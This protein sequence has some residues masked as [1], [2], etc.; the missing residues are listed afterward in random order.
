MTK[1]ILNVLPNPGSNAI[2]STAVSK[3]PGQDDHGF[4]DQLTKAR[5]DA[6][7]STDTTPSRQKQSAVRSTASVKKPQTGQNASDVTAETSEATDAEAAATAQE[8][9]PQPPIDEPVKPQAPQQSGKVK[10]AAAAEDSQQE[11]AAA[12]DPEQSK[13]NGQLP[14][15][16]QQI[17]AATAQPSESGKPTPSPQRQSQAHDDDAAASSD[18]SLA[19]ASAA[20]TA[21]VATLPKPSPSQP[22]SATPQAQNA[23]G[24]QTDDRANVSP[25]RGEDD[26]AKDA[27]AKTSQSGQTQTVVAT[28]GDDADDAAQPGDAGDDKKP[29]VA[30]TPSATPATDLTQAVADGVGLKAAVS[31]AAATDATGAAPSADSI[32]QSNHDKIVTAIAG[33]LIPRGGTMQIRLDPPELG[34]LHVSVKVQ[35]G[36]ISASFQ[37]SNDEATRL[38]SH[39]LGQLKQS[40]EMQGLS[41]ERLQVHRASAS[42]DSNSKSNQDGGRQGG[43]D[44][45]TAQQEQQHRQMMRRLWR[46]AALGRDELDLVA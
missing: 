23:A 40:L 20:A 44:D 13:Q 33:K 1:S 41:V 16:D 9:Q 8:A 32:V 24:P 15:I 35:D 43:D 46:R 7:Q 28:D 37:T 27:A 30:K 31:H 18:T 17:A 25:F 14:V 34:T 22:P 36:V 19:A 3:S 26:Q 21:T 10:G 29:V 2:A 45:R 5:S 11:A 38:L 4:S 6:R 39:T 42:E 12:Q